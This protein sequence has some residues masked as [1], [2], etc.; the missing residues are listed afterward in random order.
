VSFFGAFAI[1]EIPGR[2]AAPFEQRAV[3]AC[4]LFFAFGALTV[5]AQD[6]NR[7]PSFFAFDF[8]DL[9]SGRRNRVKHLVG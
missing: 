6:W 8:L 7:I 3:V 1:P 4:S 2:A 5:N 9:T